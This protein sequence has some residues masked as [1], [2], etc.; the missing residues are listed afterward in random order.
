MSDGAPVVTAGRKLG[1]HTATALEPPGIPGAGRRSV[2]VPQHPPG[3]TS[4]VEDPAMTPDEPA[5]PDLSHADLVTRGAAAQLAGDPDHAVQLLQ[6]AHRGQLAHGAV[7]EAL[8]SAYL[9][10]LTFGTSGRPALFSGWLGRAQRLLDE[11]PDRGDGAVSQGYVA[12]LELHQSLGEGE[13]E[14]VGALAVEVAAVG[15]RH[16]EPDLT[17]LGLAAQGRHAIYS[18]DVPRGLALLDEAMAGVLAGEAGGLVAGMVF[19]AAIEGCQEIGATDR[20]CQWTSG[21]QTWCRV[22]PGPTPFAGNCALHHAQVLTLHGAWGEA[23][24][25]LATARDRCQDQGMP[26]TAGY[27][28]QERGELLRLRGDHDGALTAYQRSAELGC[29]PQPGL[30]QLWLARGQG[31]AAAV[32]VRRCLAETAVPARRVHLLPGAIEILLGVGDADRARALRDEL[33]GLAAMTRCDPVVGAAAQARATVALAEGDPEGALAGAR[34]AVRAWTAAGAPFEVGRARVVLARALRGLGDA[35]SARAELEAAGAAFEALGAVPS[36][37]EVAGLLGT[38][39]EPPGGLTPREVEVLRLVTA[40]R[41]NRDIAAE[42]F[43]SEKTVARHLSNIYG[44]LDVDSRTRA[45]AY[46]FQHGLA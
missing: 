12:V 29:D 17:A 10:A 25:E 33:D 15:R 28:E 45:A 3:V 11:L 19:C 1:D 6:R 8:H 16:G 40:G 20:M 22:Q 46:A 14:R 42:L 41:S 32:A 13:F 37:E 5:D 34:T 43:L 38:A 24:E 35:E 27:A 36:L 4:L 18:G 44:K 26:L 39:D 7:A 21:L 30:A 9:L 31:A 2:P 23:I